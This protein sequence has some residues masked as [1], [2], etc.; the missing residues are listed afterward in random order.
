MF[1]KQVRTENMEYRFLFQKGEE[2][3]FETIVEQ[4]L[5]LEANRM[6]KQQ[7]V[8]AIQKATCY[9]KHWERAVLKENASFAEATKSSFGHIHKI[10]CKI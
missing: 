4:Y 3:P 7:I 9:P 2:I 1:P 8:R 5:L 10:E 6:Q